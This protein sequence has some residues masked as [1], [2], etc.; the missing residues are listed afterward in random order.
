MRMGRNSTVKSAKLCIQGKNTYTNWEISQKKLRRIKGS[1]LPDV[2]SITAGC[3][4]DIATKNKTM[5]IQEIIL[6]Q[7]Q[8]NKQKKQN[9][10]PHLTEYY[11]LF[12]MQKKVQNVGLDSLHV[13]LNHW[14]FASDKRL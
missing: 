14:I 3:Q 1:G 5:K 6:P 12:E 8:G 2:C 9:P 4:S 10:K 11:I 13:S 7:R